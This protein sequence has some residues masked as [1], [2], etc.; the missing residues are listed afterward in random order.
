[1]IGSVVVTLLQSVTV[2]VVVTSVRTTVSTIRGVTNVVVVGFMTVCVRI[3]LCTSTSVRLTCVDLVVTSVWVAILVRGTKVV[4]FTVDTDVTTVPGFTSVIVS[5]EMIVEG[6][7]RV[8]VMASTE[9]PCSSIVAVI[10]LD[11]ILFQVFVTVN[12]SVVA[13]HVGTIFLSISRYNFF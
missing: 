12:V 13:S 10:V 8:F 11:T 4:C 2:V 7:T 5:V 3:M 9:W 6:M 1:M